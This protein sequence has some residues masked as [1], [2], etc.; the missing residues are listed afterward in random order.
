MLS[1]KAVKKRYPE[2]RGKYRSRLSGGMERKM[3]GNSGK[4][5]KK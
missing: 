1:E 4:R 3:A 2:K 5:R